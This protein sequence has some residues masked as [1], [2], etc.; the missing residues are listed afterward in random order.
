MVDPQLIE[1]IRRCNSERLQFGNRESELESALEEAHRVST[2]L[3]V[4]GTLAPGEPNESVLQPVSGEWIQI[5]MEGNR[6]T[7][8][9]GLDCGFP[10]YQWVPGG[11]VHA[12]LLLVSQ[13]L[14]SHWDRLDEFEGPAYRRVLIPVTQAGGIITVA[15]V[16]EALHAPATRD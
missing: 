8:D 7:I 10:G 16:Y 2:K 13:L 1:R 11:H 4:Y 14:P 12:A 5:S 15:N 9:E 6:F 3:V